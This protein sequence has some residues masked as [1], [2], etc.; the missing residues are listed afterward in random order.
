MLSVS[1][2]L[3]IE[4]GRARLSVPEGRTRDGQVVRRPQSADLVP[5]GRQIEVA[6]QWRRPLAVGAELRLGGSWTRQRNHIAAA[7]PEFTFL[8]GLS[9][10]LQARHR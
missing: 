8:A 10:G 2:P 3:R 6:V 1:Q 4:D 7:A 5:S 9:F